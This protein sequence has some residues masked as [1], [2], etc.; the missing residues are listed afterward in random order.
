MQLIDVL[1]DGNVP[2]G[3]TEEDV[4]NTAVVLKNASF[5]WDSVVRCDRYCAADSLMPNLF[6]CEQAEKTNT[7]AVKPGKPVPAKIVAS[8]GSVNAEFPGLQNINLN[9]KSGELVAII[10]LVG[11]CVNVYAFGHARV[12]IPCSC[13]GKTSLL[14][15]ILGQML[16]T[17]GIH[18][19]RGVQNAMVFLN[20]KRF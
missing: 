17:G 6:C 16:K 13:S 1:A 3:L 4:T 14:Q 11:R 10:G 8:K 9:V 7:S 19:V 12:P 5:K 15:A 18:A 20:F 2:E